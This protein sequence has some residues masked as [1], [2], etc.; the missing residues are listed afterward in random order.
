MSP[1]AVLLAAPGLAGEPELV[2]ACHRPGTGLTVARRCVDLADLLAAAEAGLAG[3]AVVGPGLPRL[4]RDGVGRLRAAGL[5][6]VGVVAAGDD[7]GARTLRALD[8]GPVAVVAAADPAGAARVLAT[9]VGEALAR[10]RGTASPAYASPRSQPRPAVPS[11]PEPPLPGDPARRR[12]PRPGGDDD[13]GVPDATGT[14][15]RSVTADPLVPGR[16]RLVAVWGPTG[17]PGRTSVALA[18]ADEA[19]RAGTATLLVDA[20]TYGGAVAVALGMLDEASGLAVACRHADAGGLDP[21]T[22][23]AAAR[24]VGPRLRVLTGIPR[25]TRWPDLRPAALD[26]L[27]RCVRDTDPLTV[28][29]TG[30]CLEQDE[31]LAF[32]TIAPRR[33]AATLTA[34]EAADEVVAVGSADPLGVARLLTA[35]PD[36]AALADETPVRVV[37]TRVRPGPLGRDAERQLRRALERHAAVADPVLVPADGAGYDACWRAGR[38]LAEAAPRS[39]ARAALQALARDLVAGHVDRPAA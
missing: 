30:F 12:E 28:V 9:T 36:L 17:A 11:R 18:L 27:W 39:P 23:A 4:G 2:A 19:A 31:E 8:V 29:D 32:D 15:P 37:L 16:G 25:A 3:V 7:T 6:V 14:A 34:L 20:D 21:A 22:L 33:N 24:S 10:G 26:A 1:V 13:P 5:A 35:L 38:T